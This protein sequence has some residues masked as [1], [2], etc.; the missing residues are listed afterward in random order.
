MT[1]YDVCY[2]DEVDWAYESAGYYSSK[3]KAFQAI[4]A[5]GIDEEEFHIQEIVLD[6]PI[7][8]DN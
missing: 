4:S 1:I 2:F 8:I 6:L 3:E 5:C 7:E